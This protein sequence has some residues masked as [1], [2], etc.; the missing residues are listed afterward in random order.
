MTEFHQQG[1]SVRGSQQSAGRDINNVFPNSAGTPLNAEETP[2]INILFLAAN[3]KSTSRLTIDEEMH[4]IEQ[5]VRASKHREV[6]VFQT[7]W[8]VQPDDLLQ[9]LNQHHPYIVHFSGYGN[10]KRLS[11]M[12]DDG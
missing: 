4:A 9:L 6:L 11:F 5:K 1:Q 10:S 12:G 2:K 8:A 3:A 7:A